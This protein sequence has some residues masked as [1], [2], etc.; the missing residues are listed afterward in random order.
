MNDDSYIYSISGRN[1]GEKYDIKTKI[2][3]MKG[4]KKIKFVRDFYTKLCLDEIHFLSSP[5]TDCVPA[6][7]PSIKH[8]KLNLK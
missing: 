5:G 1:A 8:S 4:I 7:Q 3:K 6:G 2:N